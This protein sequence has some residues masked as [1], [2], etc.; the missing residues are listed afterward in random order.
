MLGVGKVVALV[1]MIA[2]L[3]AVSLLTAGAQDRTTPINLLVSAVDCPDF[4]AL[5]AGGCEP[6]AGVAFTVTLPSGEEIGACTTEIDTMQDRTAGFCSVE[7]PLGTLVVT[8]DLSTVTEGYA[9]VENP[10]TVEIG[11]QDPD[12][13][14]YLPTAG[15]V[16][17]AQAEPTP[18]PTQSVA[19]PTE[20]LAPTAVP[21]RGTGTTTLPSTGA[22]TGAGREASLLA[23]ALLALS[24]GAAVV[25]R[26]RFA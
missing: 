8:E 23:G 14:T 16:N 10:R 19:R 21:A 4:E 25:L 12:R 9:P 7:V 18:E 15:F 1:V 20:D 22:G 26:R 13:T 24:I 5:S 2:G 11:P 6:A 17:V 3:G